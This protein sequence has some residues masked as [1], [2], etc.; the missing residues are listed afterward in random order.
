MQGF[1]TFLRLGSTFKSKTNLERTIM[2]NSNF[3]EHLLVVLGNNLKKIQDT[4]VFLGA[5]DE[6]FGSTF[7]PGSTGWETLV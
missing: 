2:A 6:S 5:P 1:P 4:W 7:D 3:W